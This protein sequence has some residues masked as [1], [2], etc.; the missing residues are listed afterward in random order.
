MKTHL[1]R[2]FKLLVEYIFP[3]KCHSCCVKIDGGFLCSEC[4]GDFHFINSNFCKK[5][6]HPFEFE[7]TEYE[8][9]LCIKCLADENR[10][11]FD[12]LV[13]C[14]VYNDSSS[15]IVLD[16]KSYGKKENIEMM[17]FFCIKKLKTVI[18][19]EKKYIITGVPM[20]YLNIFKRGF[21]QTFAVAKSI[22]SH[23]GNVEFRHDVLIKKK[24]TKNQV[25]LTRKQ[26]EENLNS[27]FA[28]S[29]IEDGFNYIIFDDVFTTG[30]TINE[31]SKTLRKSV[32]KE[33][34]II[35]VSFCR[36]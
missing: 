32:E 4:Y 10:F 26:R 29:K 25:R 12:T 19:P 35:C 5:C 30:S 15:K 16:L 17:T 24:F 14:C 2:S 21:N 23:F 36:T 1:H 13:S 27:A 7:D 8:N 3:K 11:Y 34:E 20:H 6:S 22:S 31:C 9:N 33:A 18:N 28:V